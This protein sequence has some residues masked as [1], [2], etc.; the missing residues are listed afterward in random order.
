MGSRRIWGVILNGSR[1]WGIFVK[2]FV[3][4]K[5]AAAPVTN[6]ELKQIHQQLIYR[7]FA[8]LTALRYQLREPRVRESIYIEHN[9]EYKKNFFTADEHENKLAD[10]LKPYLDYKEY[11]LIMSKTNK[12]A[13]I[14]TLQ[15]ANL[16]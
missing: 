14:I 6:E 8:W 1:S 16:R 11:H 13:Q 2:D 7:Q 5:H 12:A 15:S 9:A 4:T 10:A 3:S